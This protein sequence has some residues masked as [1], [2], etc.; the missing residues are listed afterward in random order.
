ME[1][2]ELGKKR[3]RLAERISRVEG[4][5]F[6]EAVRLVP[7]SEA[8]VRKL[9]DRLNSNHGADRSP[10]GQKIARA[11]ARSRDTGESFGT[12]ARHTR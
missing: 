2:V 1:Q 8:E 11:N 4:I 5:P 6:D 3:I 12:A 10:N 7:S 9:V